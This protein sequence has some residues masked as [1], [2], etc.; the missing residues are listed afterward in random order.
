MQTFHVILDLSKKITSAIKNFP[1]DFEVLTVYFF[2][3]SRKENLTYEFFQKREKEEKLPISLEKT[4]IVL[5]QITDK[6]IT[7]KERKFTG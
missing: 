4:A 6:E 2:W 1:S 5:I 7:D 3:N